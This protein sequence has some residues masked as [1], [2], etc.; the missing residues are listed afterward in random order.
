MEKTSVQDSDFPYTYT[1]QRERNLSQHTLILETDF[2]D[3]FIGRITGY[4]R[5]NERAHAPKTLTVNDKKVSEIAFCHSDQTGAYS[6]LQ[7][8]FPPGLNRLEISGRLVSTYEYTIYW[9]K[10]L[11]T[12]PAKCLL[13][14]T[15]TGLILFLRSF[16]SP[17]LLR[18]KY[19]HPVLTLSSMIA[20]I[21]FALTFSFHSSTQCLT[22]LGQKTQPG[23]S[24]REKFDQFLES[25]AHRNKRKDNY[26]VCVLG[27]ST[28]RFELVDRFMPRFKYRHENDQSETL[29]IYGVSFFGMGPREYYLLMNR[30]SVEQPDIVV[31]P[32]HLRLFTDYLMR[33]EHN[34]IDTFNQYLQWSEIPRALSIKVAD[35]QFEWENLLLQKADAHFFD[36]RIA[37]L[38]N[39]TKNELQ[40]QYDFYLENHPHLQPDDWEVMPENTDNSI[41][42]EPSGYELL[43]QEDH[44]ILPLYD[45]IIRLAKK[46]HIQILFY[47]VGLDDTMQAELGLQMHVDE[48]YRF[49]EK[50]LKQDSNALF[51]WPPTPIPS[52]LYVDAWGHMNEEGIHTVADDIFDKIT[53]MYSDQ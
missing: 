38:A 3:G 29:E 17:R 5:E 23:V 8:K 47:P 22:Q 7:L 37:P 20:T 2:P 19:L 14:W 35:R 43:I 30:L 28:H 9:E 31:I 26:S 12:T 53:G 39:G 6:S 16:A 10:K 1:M 15:L 33:Q 11:P 51:Y 4:V 21:A 48:N 34:R 13:I 25:S 42:R 32:V 49:L 24:E 18:Q 52:H 50:Y 36:S 45:G 44:M 27:D 40:V 46:H 41:S